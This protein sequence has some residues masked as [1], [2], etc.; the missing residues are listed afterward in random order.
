MKLFYNGR[1]CYVVVKEFKSK[2]FIKQKKL[3]R[4]NKW[5][6]MC[7]REMKIV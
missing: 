2:C 4:D 7:K 1:S 6:P 5:K 3:K